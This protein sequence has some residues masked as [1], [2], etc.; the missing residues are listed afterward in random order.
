MKFELL[1]D[2]FTS[3]IVKKCINKV[4]TPFSLAFA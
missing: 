1:D 4:S 2:Y 3:Y